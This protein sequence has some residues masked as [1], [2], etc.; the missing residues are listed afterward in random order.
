MQYSKARPTV[1]IR[2]YTDIYE[3]IKKVSYDKRVSLSD[4]LDLILTEQNTDKFKKIAD[5][6][7]KRIEGFLR[8]VDSMTDYVSKNGDIPKK[9]WNAEFSKFYEKDIP[10][11]DEINKLL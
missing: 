3:R 2:V 6:R 1:G 5:L 4:A 9:F 10:L 11:V 8:L 7:E